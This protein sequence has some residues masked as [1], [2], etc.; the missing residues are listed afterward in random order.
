MREVEPSRFYLLRA[1]SSFPGKSHQPCPDG[2]CWLGRDGSAHP[3]SQSGHSGAG[4]RQSA[5]GMCFEVPQNTIKLRISFTL[6]QWGR[7]SPGP[8]RSAA[9]QDWL[10]WV[11]RGA[12]AQSRHPTLSL[13]YVD[14]SQESQFEICLPASDRSK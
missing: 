8:L 7:K 5:L 10:C 14:L 6:R 2:S 13:F 4:S 12:A 11:G 3:S 1:S 9:H